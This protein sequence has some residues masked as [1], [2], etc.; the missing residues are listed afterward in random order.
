LHFIVKELVDNNFLT[1]DF[2]DDLKPIG[3]FRDK[4]STLS[5]NVS[6]EE[7]EIMTMRI[8]LFYVHRIF[9]ETPF[10]EP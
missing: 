3:E 9:L 4:L 1:K 8:N 6:I 2:Y 7:I 10:Y 5:D